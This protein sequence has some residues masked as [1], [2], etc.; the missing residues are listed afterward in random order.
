L[1]NT[2]IVDSTV[3]DAVETSMALW[4]E[5]AAETNRKTLV[6]LLMMEKQ[7]SVS[8][9]YRQVMPEVTVITVV[10]TL[11]LMV[12]ARKQSQHPLNASHKEG[13]CSLLPAHDHKEEHSHSHS[14]TGT[15]MYAM[16]FKHKPSWSEEGFTFCWWSAA[17]HLYLWAKKGE[18]RRRSLLVGVEAKKKGV[19]RSCPAR[20]RL[21]FCS[22]VGF[23]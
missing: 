3:S 15:L 14:S 13:G 21:M 2:K 22:I 12:H 5:I 19:P 7:A 9:Q 10:I 8:L 6:L 17:T 4:D 23:G 16:R 20:F 18:A 11:A 1:A